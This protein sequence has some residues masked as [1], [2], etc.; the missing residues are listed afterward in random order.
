MRS[1]GRRSVRETKLPQRDWSWVLGGRAIPFTAKYI[2]AVKPEQS[3]PFRSIPPLRYLTPSQRSAS[4]FQAA[5]EIT[6]RGK[7]GSF[8]GF[9]RRKLL[10]E[11]A[12]GLVARFGTQRTGWRPVELGPN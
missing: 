5:G 7:G 10:V 3:M 1:P 9:Y 11:V 12:D 4:A 6:F 8:L 2:C